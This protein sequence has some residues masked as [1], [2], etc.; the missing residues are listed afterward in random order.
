MFYAL[1]ITDLPMRRVKENG[2][3]TLFCPNEVLDKETVT[4]LMDV[5][6]EE[7]EKRYT[8][9]EAESHGRKTLEAQQLWFRTLE[10][11]MEVGTPHML[12]KELAN[13][14]SNQQNLGTIHKSKLRT[15]IIGLTSAGEVTVCNLASIAFP[16]FVQIRG[17]TYGHKRLYEVTRV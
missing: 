13:R 2:E 17:M 3:W 7:F 10:S 11:Q 4:G 6:G 8:K 9:V 16:S 15:E 14:K 12:Y 5:C 1:W